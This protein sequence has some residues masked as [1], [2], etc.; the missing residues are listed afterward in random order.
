MTTTSTSLENIEDA[1]VGND[2]HHQD[3]KDDAGIDHDAE[4]ATAKDNDVGRHHHGEARVP[5]VEAGTWTAAPSS[6]SSRD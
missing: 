3:T 1:A 5:V 6:S 2:D 4:G